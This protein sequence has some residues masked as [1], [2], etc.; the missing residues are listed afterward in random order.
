M[1]EREVNRDV[2]FAA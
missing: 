1:A 2:K